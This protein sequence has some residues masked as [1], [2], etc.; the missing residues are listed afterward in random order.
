MYH[1]KKPA[2]GHQG[3]DKSRRPANIASR[4]THMDKVEKHQAENIQKC[5]AGMTCSHSSDDE[6]QEE[7]EERYLVQ[8]MTFLPI[9][10]I[11]C[12]NGH[13]KRFLKTNG[14]PL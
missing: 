11:F 12:I 9:G 3:N 5:Q 7:H 14:E 6:V 8:A 4:E 10:N 2:H 1:Y 13:P